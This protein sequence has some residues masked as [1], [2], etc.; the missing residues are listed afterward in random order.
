MSTEEA[1]TTV[2]DD[3]KRVISG[4][5]LETAE[6]EMPCVCLP[7]YTGRGMFDPH[8][9]CDDRDDLT[10]EA[11][12]AGKHEVFLAL[13]GL[14]ARWRERGEQSRSYGGVLPVNRLLGQCADELEEALRKDSSD[15]HR[16]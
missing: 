16:G 8:C 10:K 9:R 6:R 13:S 1:S 12:E 2:A 11:Y 3:R 14:A 7:D 4:E 5:L 15:E